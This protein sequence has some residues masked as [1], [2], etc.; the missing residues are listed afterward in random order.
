MPPAPFPPESRLRQSDEFAAVFRNGRRHV[1]SGL[2][3]IVAPGG[4]EQARLG[5]ALAKR[6][7]ARAV[8]RNR[9]KRVIRESFRAVCGKLDTVD[10][11]VLARSGTADMSNRR[12]FGQLHSIWQDVAAAHA[13]QRHEPAD[14]Q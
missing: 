3:V 6:R 10:I 12:L 8:D 2:V 7:I 4:H 9:V 11:V 14:R 1:R 5:L 13:A